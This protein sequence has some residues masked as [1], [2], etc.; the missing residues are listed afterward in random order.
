MNW[1]EIL[2]KVFELCIIPLLGVGTLYLVKWLA[3]KRDEVLVKI[4]N[5]TADKYVAMLFDTIATC[6]SA[7]TQTY[8][9]SLK[10][11]GQFDAAAQKAAFE[12]TY[13][14]VLATL[15]EEAKMYLTSLYGDL[16]AFLTARIEAEVKAQK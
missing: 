15:T 9:E 12:L 10:K 11:S 14:A 4:D 16:N 5:D 13:A 7:T 3:A 1:L 2:S 6:V 8:V